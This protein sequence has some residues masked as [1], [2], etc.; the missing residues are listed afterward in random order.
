MLAIKITKSAYVFF[1]VYVLTK[2]PDSIN[3][4]SIGIIVF[5]AGVLVDYWQSFH[6]SKKNNMKSH[7]KYFIYA[8]GM[9]ISI[10]T[11]IFGLIGLDGS[12]VFIETGNT[13]SIANNVEQF[14][15]INFCFK[16]F[17]F[18]RFFGCIFIILTGIDFYEPRNKKIESTIST[19]AA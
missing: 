6:I 11:V 9:A 8:F 1:S 16:F 5:S 12:L 3:S 7:F 10:I 17:P 15:I 2:L 19:E 4:F 18:C 14:G 13:M